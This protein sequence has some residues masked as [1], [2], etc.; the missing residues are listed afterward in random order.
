M[1]SSPATERAP[2]PGAAGMP[3]DPGAAY[4]V[5]ELRKLRDWIDRQLDNTTRPYDA[6]LRD[7]VDRT[8]RLL[9][10]GPTPTTRQGK[11]PSPRLDDPR[12]VFSAACAVSGL[13]LEQI[14]GKDHRRCVCHARHGVMLVLRRH[15]G[16]TLA[17][18]GALFGRHHAT[19]LHAT[20]NPS[21]GTQHVARRI[22]KRLQLAVSGREGRHGS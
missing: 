22:E 4:Y 13:E 3:E 14:V 7:A 15:T 12:L 10:H 17:E 19:V 2:V 18:I 1:N 21:Q 8:D 11:T 6:I 20:V 16:M 9:Q 5:R